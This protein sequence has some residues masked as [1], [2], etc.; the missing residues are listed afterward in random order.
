MENALKQKKSAQKNDLKF[1]DRVALIDNVKGL[2]VIIFMLSQAMIQI[3]GAIGGN[4]L[5]DQIPLGAWFWHGGDIEGIPFW[6]YFGFAFL[7]L[8]PIAFFFVIGV[9]AFWSFEKRIPYDGAKATLKRFFMR[10]TAIVGIFL[11]TNIIASIFLANNGVISSS[12]NWGTIPSI[13]F[14]GMILTLFIAVPQIRR[15]WWTKL[16][17]GAGVLAFYH[18]F[19]ALLKNFNGTE[20]GPMACIGYAAAV[21]LAAALGDLQRKGILWYTIGTAVLFVLSHLAKT[22]WGAA[23]YGDYNATYMIMALNLINLAYYV[24]YILDK[25]FLKGRP[26]PLLATMGRNI[27]LYLILTGMFLN[28]AFNVVPFFKT[29]NVPGIYIIQLVVLICYFILAAFLEKK[30]IVFKL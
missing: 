5:R 16:V 13:G 10:N 11:P 15:H 1:K 26:I 29:T 20:G 9:V 24:F 23:V 22:Y 4:V 19:Y 18:Y 17:V 7:D 27:M 14:T 21:L 2:L 25:I 8:G 6:N 12:W 28:T 3:N 30:K